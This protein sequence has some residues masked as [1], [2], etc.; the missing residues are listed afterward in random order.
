M[1]LVALAFISAFAYTIYLFYKGYNNYKRAFNNQLSDYQ[2][3]VVKVILE[4]KLP[5]FTNLSSDGK[6]KFLKRI[7]HLYNAFEFQGRKGILVNVEMKTLICSAIAQVTF[8][9][10]VFDLDKFHTII[11]FPSTFQ[12]TEY[13]PKMKGATSESGKIYFSWEDLKYGFHIPDDGINLAIHE[14]THAIKINYLS[15][16]VTL[17]YKIYKDWEFEAETSMV[18]NEKSQDPF[19]RKYVKTNMHEF[20]SGVLEN[21]FERPEEFLKRFPRL[22]AATCLLL[23]QNPLNVRQDYMV[24]SKKYFT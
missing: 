18:D 21:F 3:N 14:I 22:F 23:N 11:V 1:W 10:K 17:Q 2:L 4:R 24:D 20:F 6:T 16:K 13:L 12:L 19:F 8:G 9:W 15:D 5:Y 7:A